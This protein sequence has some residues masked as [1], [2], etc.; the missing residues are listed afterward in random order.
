MRILMFSSPP[1]STFLSSFFRFSSVSSCIVLPVFFFA[2]YSSVPPEILL[3]PVL[4]ALGGNPY[5]RHAF[6]RSR[7]SFVKVFPSLA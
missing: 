6:R 1:F 4:F 3:T 2:S 7:H 5:L